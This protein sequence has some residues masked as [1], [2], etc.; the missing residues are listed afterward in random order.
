MARIAAGG[1]ARLID[2]WSVNRC[3]NQRFQVVIASPASGGAATAESTATPAKAA[4]PAESA[5]TETASARPAAAGPARPPAAAAAHSV[6]ERDDESDQPAD[7]R[8]REHARGQPDDGAYDPS[9]NSGPDNPTE[10]APEDCIGHDERDEQQEYRLE[11]D[12]AMYAVDDHS[13]SRR[14]QVFSLD[15][16]HERAGSGDDAAVEVV[17]LEVRRDDFGYHSPRDAVRDRAF[18]TAAD[19]DAKL[20][21]VLRDDE[22][23]TVVDARAADLPGFGEADRVL[24]DSLGLCRRQHQHRDLA[25]FAALELAQARIEILNLLRREGPGKVGDVRPERRHGDFAGSGRQA[26]EQQNRPGR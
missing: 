1:N 10:K 7:D 13:R 3:R 11:I 17:R 23:D 15:Q 5:S 8:E 9:G 2:P 4:A 16:F 12:R 26:R 25:A 21:V 22:N 14:R 6:D 18:E 24:L 20:P 19:F